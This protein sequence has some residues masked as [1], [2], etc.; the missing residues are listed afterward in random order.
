MVMERKGERV[1]AFEKFN[2]LFA[3]LQI[4]QR[5]CTSAV[6]KGFVGSSMKTTMEATKK[7]WSDSL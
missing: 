6:E 1:S 5:G 2:I 4:N 7:E 3:C